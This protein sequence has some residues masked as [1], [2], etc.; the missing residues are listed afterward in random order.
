V[1]FAITV[2]APAGSFACVAVF[3]EFNAG[4]EGVEGVRRMN[5]R[6]VEREYRKSCVGLASAGGGGESGSSFTYVGGAV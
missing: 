5:G 2:G 6:A 1:V 4:K 3:A